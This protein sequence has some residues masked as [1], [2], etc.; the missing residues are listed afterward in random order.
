MTRPL[1]GGYVR[2]GRIGRLSWT[3]SESPPP[4]RRMEGG[5]VR[6]P[7]HRTYYPKQQRCAM[8]E[9]VLATRV[10]S[11]SAKQRTV[12]YLPRHNP[13]PSLTAVYLWYS[14]HEMRQYSSRM[15]ELC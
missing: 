14:R 7:P 2:C 15:A 8:R 5:V 12:F 11:Y 9:P 6:P 13:A 1:G 4:S 3:C 10:I